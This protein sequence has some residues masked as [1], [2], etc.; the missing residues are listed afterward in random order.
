MLG[1]LALLVLRAPPRRIALRRRPPAAPVSTGPAPDLPGLDRRSLDRAVSTGH[2]LVAG[3]RRASPDGDD[4]IG[5]DAWVGRGDW[6]RGDR[7]GWPGAGAAAVGGWSGGRAA[8]WRVAGWVGIAVLAWLLG[9]VALGVAAVLVGVWHLVRAPRPR[10]LIVAAAALL[11]AVPV[12]WLAAAAG[13]QRRPVRAGGRRRPL[14]APAGR[15][16][17]LL[18]AV[19]VTRAER[20]RR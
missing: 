11:A 6:C 2:R 17:L 7:A 19:G 18:L 5:R 1:C 8:V 9:G 3:S 16:G 12:V 4:R 20:R 10:T 14:A 15:A 13:H